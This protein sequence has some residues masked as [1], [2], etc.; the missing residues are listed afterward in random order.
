[1][2]GYFDNSPASLLSFMVNEEKLTEE[3]IAAL[4]KI[5]DKF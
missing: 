1:M 2:K 4:K 3:E 5:I